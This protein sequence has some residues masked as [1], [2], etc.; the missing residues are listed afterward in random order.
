MRVIN[1][2]EFLFLLKLACLLTFSPSVLFFSM[3]SPTV[4]VSYPKGELGGPV[5]E[6]VETGGAGESKPS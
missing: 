5:S 3:A 4:K 1:I 2:G 6:V